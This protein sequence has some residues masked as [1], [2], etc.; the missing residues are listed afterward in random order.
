MDVVDV[1]E[2]DERDDG[3]I[4]GSRH[5]PFRLIRALGGRPDGRDR[6]VVT[7]CESGSRAAIA[8]SILAA[9]G[10]DARPVRRGARRGSHG[11]P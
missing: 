8:A 4:P 3:Y 5:I 7:I 2:E 10:A 9:S 1:R 11:E 6:P